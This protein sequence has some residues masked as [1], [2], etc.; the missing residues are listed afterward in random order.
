MSSN[1]ACDYIVAASANKSR[2]HQSPLSQRDEF[3]FTSLL[4]EL[5]PPFAATTLLLVTKGSVRYDARSMI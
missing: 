2:I 1:L 3:F 4:P 5:V